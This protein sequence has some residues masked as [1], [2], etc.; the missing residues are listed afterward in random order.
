MDKL[1]RLV[2]SLLWAGLFCVGS[3]VLLNA[4]LEAP[5]PIIP[6]VFVIGLLGLLVFGLRWRF[7]RSV[8]FYR[9]VEQHAA[10]RGVTYRSEDR[11]RRD[12]LQYAQ[13]GVVLL[14]LTGSVVLTT[15]FRTFWFIVGFAVLGWAAVI[16]LG[17]YRRNLP[18]RIWRQFAARHR[19]SFSSNGQWRIEGEYEQRPLVMERLPPAPLWSRSSGDQGETIHHLRIVVPVDS[20]EEYTLHWQWGTLRGQPELMVHALLEMTDLSQRLAAAAPDTFVLVES[21]L[22]L[23]RQEAITD[24]AELQFLADLVCD[25]ADAV[26]TLQ[27]WL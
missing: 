12:Y 10:Q 5:S 27:A 3:D 19:L 2:A 9:A 6:A 23:E 26:E 22:L 11:L 4:V 8:A 20:P 18:K 21:V 7:R 16:A 14:A 17:L 15:L 13:V 25:T 1:I 24:E